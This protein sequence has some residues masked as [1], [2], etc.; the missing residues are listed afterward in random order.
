MSKQTRIGNLIL[1]GGNKPLIQSMT[2]FAPKDTEN[3]IN[4]IR[5]LTDAGCEIVRFCVADEKDAEG[6]KRIK[7]QTSIP[8]VADVHFDYRLGIKAVENGAD[9]LRI[10]PG[11]IGGEKELKAVAD[12]VKAHNVPVRVGAN[13]G[14]IEKELLKKYGV[15]ATALVESAMNNVRLLEKFGVQNIVVSV[16]AS[17]VKLTVES[18]RK[19]S[20]ICDYPLHIG[21][22]E[23]GGGEMGETKNAIGIGSLL[24][25]G[26][27]DTLR[28]SLS[29]DPLRE[30]AVA[31]TILRSAGIDE[32]FV[33][34]VACP[35]CGRCCWDCM[36]F[37][38]KVANETK[39][40]NEKL[41][42][43][44][45]GCVVNG[46]GEGKHA[47][48]GIAG[49]KDKAVIFKKG[50]I[51]AELNFSEAEEVF[52]KELYKCLKWKK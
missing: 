33:N 29:D 45:M 23:A 19:L 32:D 50:E 40:V 5:A 28:V 18:Y 44:V 27:G 20:K 36:A 26:I 24:L 13:S 46:V 4:Q 22:T 6:I 16:K 42:V 7:S 48:V 51:V 9:K 8:L 37:A 25:D 15:S 10:N 3:C 12:C 34:V 11:N 2:T 38:K 1:G 30:V 14:S 43:A 17:S 41:T 21:V 35:T 31:K 52:F 49:G 39:N 47:D